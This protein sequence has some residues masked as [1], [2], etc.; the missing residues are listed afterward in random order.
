MISLLEDSRGHVV[1]VLYKENKTASVK[2]KF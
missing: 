2:V 1:G